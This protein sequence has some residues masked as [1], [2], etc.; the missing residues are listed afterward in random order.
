MRRALFERFIREV[1][2][3]DYIIE[4]K[5]FQIFVHEAGE[6][7]KRLETLPKQMPMQI[8]EK[9][10]LSFKIEEE[11][12]TTEVAK[13]REKINMFIIFL[14]KADMMMQKAKENMKE[15][16]GH[17]DKLKDNYLRMYYAFMKY[18]DIAIDYFSDC[19]VSKRT[20][21]HPGVGDTKQKVVDAFNQVNN[22]YSDAY[23]WLKGEQLDMKGM[24]DGLIGRENVMRQQIA[25]EQKRRDNQLEL[26]KLEMGKTSFKNFFKS[27][28]S[29]D[30]SKITLKAQIEAAAHSIEDYRKLT[31][32]ITILH[33]LVVIDKFKKTKVTQYKRMLR[34]FSVREITNC[35][36]TANLCHGILQ[37]DDIK[38]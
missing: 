32:F 6:I 8:L 34:A 25:A 5:E 17:H 7:T 27:K 4:S 20:M 13:F 26:D 18:E 28:D 37:L 9:Y 22:P 19:D 33:G 12:E 24:L 3:Y 21:T 35:H 2:K 11:Q 14:K 23:I 36:I 1:A 15:M 31:N 30:N 29:K 38:N 16:V 10:R